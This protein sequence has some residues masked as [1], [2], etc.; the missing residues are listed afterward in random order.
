MDRARQFLINVVPHLVAGCAKLLRV[1]QFQ[2]GIESTPE[3]DAANE[4]T[5]RQKCKTE[6]CGRFAE[7]FPDRC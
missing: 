1:R 7:D 3:H 2:C 4:T 5:E 6:R